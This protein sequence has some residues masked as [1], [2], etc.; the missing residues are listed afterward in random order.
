MD[1][2]NFT[3]DYS[4]KV[5]LHAHTYPCSGCGH[6][7]PED[8][9]ELYAQ[10]GADAIVITNHLASHYCAKMG[11]TPAE[12]VNT[13]LD[14]YYR[15][16]KRGD[17]LGVSVI[18]GVE[19]RFES[20]NENDYLVYGVEPSDIEKMLP[21]LETGVSDFYRDFKCEKHL[22]FQAHPFRKGMV[23]A[24]LD[25]IDGIESFNAHPN[26]N[27]RLG[28]AARYATDNSLLAIG[29]SDFHEADYCGVCLM[30][31]KTVPKDS[32]EL[33]KILRSRDYFFDM[34]GTL[35]FLNNN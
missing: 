34:S 9:V 6:V 14:D 18:L 22:V 1:I 20:E 30:R 17:E 24:P 15:A 5:E 23:L 25:S 19:I 4:A 21:Y 2:L 33:V 16:K 35:V 29:G 13:Y 32:F 11:N 10:N 8:T 12:I 26:H 7:L 27:G 31:C 28:L 3:K